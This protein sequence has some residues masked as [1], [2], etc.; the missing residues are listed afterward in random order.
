MELKA[1]SKIYLKTKSLAIKTA[2]C[3]SALLNILASTFWY[4]SSSLLIK[5]KLQAAQNKL[6]R[7]IWKLSP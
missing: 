2:L 7:F 4:R 3:D 6:I 1:P 5:N